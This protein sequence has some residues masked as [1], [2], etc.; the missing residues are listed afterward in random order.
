MLRSPAAWRTVQSPLAHGIRSRSRTERI[1]RLIRESEAYLP[2]HPLSAHDWFEHARR[3]MPRLTCGFWFRAGIPLESLARTFGL[4]WAGLA[5]NADE[6]C[7]SSRTASIV[8]PA[9]AKLCSWRLPSCCP[10]ACGRRCFAGSTMAA[11]WRLPRL[12]AGW[13]RCHGAPAYVMNSFRERC[14]PA[15]EPRRRSALASRSAA[16]RRAAR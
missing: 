15:S 13:W 8:Q 3:Q 10:H 14:P 12:A 9:F 6:A 7:Y 4:M 2:A 1:G 11:S 16:R 5:L